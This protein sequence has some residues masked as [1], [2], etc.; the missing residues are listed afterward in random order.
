M[1]IKAKEK[2]NE[3]HNN[4]KAKKKDSVHTSHTIKRIKKYCVVTV[5]Y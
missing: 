5:Y 3:K 1:I 2:K 4:Q